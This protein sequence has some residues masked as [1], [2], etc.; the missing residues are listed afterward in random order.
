[1]TAGAARHRYL[2]ALGSNMRHPAFGSPRA[3]V[4]AALIELDR[5]FGVRAVSCVVQSAPL[6]PSRR[7]YANAAAV[8]AAGLAPQDMLAALQAIERAFGRRRRGQRW[9]AR[10]L[11]IDLI[12]W[13]GG[14]LVAQGLQI[15]H[16]AFRER[17]FVLEPAA[18]IAPCWRDPTTGLSLRQLH[19][20]LTR[21]RPL[22]R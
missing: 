22:P 9:G 8:L 10:V 16:P 6:G 5:Q 3:V 13:S 1:M 15:P 12:L 19:A 7:R 4:D 11:D 18:A 17:R 2:V 14:A 20:R 21:P